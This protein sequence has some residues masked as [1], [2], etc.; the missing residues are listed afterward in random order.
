MLE[1]ARENL[2]SLG[3]GDEYFAEKIFTADT[4]YHSDTNLRKCQRRP[5]TTTDAPRAKDSGG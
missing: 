4:N 1:G 2:Q 3:R 5:P